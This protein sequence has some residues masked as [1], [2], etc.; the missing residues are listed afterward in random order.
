M[1]WR[2]EKGYVLGWTPSFMNRSDKPKICKK[3]INLNSYIEIIKNIKFKRVYGMC[4]EI[5]YSK[6]SIFGVS[7]HDFKM[8]GKTSKRNYLINTMT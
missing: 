3:T 4:G 7:V 5:C 8:K 2:V 1:R 6:Y